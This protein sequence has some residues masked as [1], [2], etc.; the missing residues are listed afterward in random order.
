MKNFLKFKNPKSKSRVVVG[1]K[2]KAKPKSKLKL[3]YFSMLGVLVL[4]VASYAGYG[5]WK[6]HELKARASSNT[7]LGAVGTGGPSYMTY[8]VYA[9]KDSVNS[10]FGP[11]WRLRI[12]TI[13]DKA[14]PPNTVVNSYVIRDNQRVNNV[15]QGGWL[16]GSI[17]GT[18]VYAH[19]QLPDT[20]S[21]AIGGRQAVRGY[22]PFRITN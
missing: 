4:S 19:Q 3:V 13:S 17:N 2:S 22:S 20:L 9:C 8:K 21:V 5:Y 14:A 6:K 15:N 11:L 7:Y 12:T 10:S 18:T 16:W 1:G